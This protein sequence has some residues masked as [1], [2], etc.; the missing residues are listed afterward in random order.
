MKQDAIKEAL[1]QR[2][3]RGLDVSIIIG[4]AEPMQETDDE[5]KKLGLA[6]KGSMPTHEDGEES[7]MEGHEDEMQD[8]SLIEEELSKLGLGKG[9]ILAKAKSGMMA[10]KGE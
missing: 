1:K 2:K 4:G 3:A 7:E 5:Q 8:K 9:S 6:P 10:K